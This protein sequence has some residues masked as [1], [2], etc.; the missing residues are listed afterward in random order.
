MQETTV[1]REAVATVTAAADETDVYIEVQDTGI[2]IPIEEQERIF[3]RFVRSEQDE[4]RAQQGTGLGLSLVQEIA[5]IHEGSIT[6]ESQPAKGSTF[7]LQ[8]PVRA[9]GTRLDVGAA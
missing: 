5:E 1:Y 6:V 2:G 7:R 4:V 3:E 8:L 9:V